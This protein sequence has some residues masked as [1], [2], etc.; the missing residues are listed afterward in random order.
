MIRKAMKLN[1][2]GTVGISVPAQFSR[3][4][5]LTLQDSVNIVLVG[6]TLHITKVV[7]A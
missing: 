1:D 2:F 7:L 3:E 5:E 6:K 4:M